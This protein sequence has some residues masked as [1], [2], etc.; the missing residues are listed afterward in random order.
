MTTEL[1]PLKLFPA[2]EGAGTPLDFSSTATHQGIY[3]AETTQR[4]VPGQ[5]LIDVDGRVFKYGYAKSALSAGYGAANGFPVSKHITY[6]V[7]PTAIAVGDESCEVTFPSSAGYAS[8]G[9]AKNELV[10][11]YIVVGH[12]TTTVENRRIVGND[13]MGSTTSTAT[14]FVE[15]PFGT[16]NSTSSGA[17]AYPNPYAYLKK[18]ALEY[19]AF[20]GVP[21]INVASAAYGWFQSWGPCWVVPGGAD[22]SPGD[23]INDRT[24]F[25]VGDG[26]V[27]FGTSLTVETG[28]QNAG[29]CID[30]TASGTSAMPLIMLQISI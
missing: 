11:G 5:R 30:T 1:T 29:F 25:F 3:L 9:F 4:F 19:N 6:A 28:Y 22:A 17:E 21:A 8:A 2:F 18:G 12:N 23:T 7:L 26:S 27:N 13:A 16:A 14:I 20:M 10:G 24:A 15:A